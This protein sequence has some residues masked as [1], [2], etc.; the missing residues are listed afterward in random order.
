M[1]HSTELLYAWERENTPCYHCDSDVTKT[2][3]TGIVGLMY[4]SDEYMVYGNGVNYRCYTSPN[5]CNG[6][7]AKAGWVYNSN[8]LE[9]Q[10]DPT[11]TWFLLPSVDSYPVLYASKVG[12]TYAY[13][14][15]GLLGVR[16]VVYLKTDIQIV[17]GDGSSGNPY[18]LQEI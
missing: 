11:H 9:G 12:A 18:K 7:N 13:Y 4:P 5:N 2:M 16:P 17:D 14:F 1:S 6:T 3:W 15:N 10:T 8:V